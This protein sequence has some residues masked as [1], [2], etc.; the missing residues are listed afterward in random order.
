MT[1]EGVIVYSNLQLEKKNVTINMSKI[2]I[3]GYMQLVQ[4]PDIENDFFCLSW[5]LDS[6]VSLAM[7]DWYENE[8]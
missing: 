1:K 8:Y 5:E 4:T 6:W 2:N 3:D 7:R